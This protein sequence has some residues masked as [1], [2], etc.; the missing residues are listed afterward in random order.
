MLFLNQINNMGV[1]LHDLTPASPMP[2]K[3]MRENPVKSYFQGTNSVLNFYQR[4]LY[5]HFGD[6]MHVTACKYSPFE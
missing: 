5:W 1:N 4:N 6:C 2:V 3:F